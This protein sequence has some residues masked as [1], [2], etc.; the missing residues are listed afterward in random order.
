MPKILL[1]DDDCPLV[2]MMTEWLCDEGYTV[3]ASDNGVT[4]LSL[5]KSFYFDVIVLDWDLPGLTGPHIC[6]SYRDWGGRTPVLMLT[7]KGAIEEKEK[8]FLSGSDDYLTKPFH[9][10]EL[11]LRIRALLGRTVSIDKRIARC[12]SLVLDLDKASIFA[13]DVDLKLSATEFALLEF[14]IRHPEQVFSA[15]A[16]ISRV[17]KSDAEVS[18]KAVRVCVSRLR[19]KLDKHDCPN[20]VTVSGFGYKLSS[21]AKADR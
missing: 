5:M 1:V 14:L 2:E 13:G 7:G 6:K 9:P 12:G 21:Q 18:D 4:A 11:S 8:G 10:K 3:E 15:D 19:E 16:L 17:W 20:I